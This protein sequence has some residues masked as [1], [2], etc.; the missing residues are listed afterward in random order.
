[1]AL[2]GAPGPLPMQVHHFLGAALECDCLVLLWSA[3]F[4]DLGCIST[5][6]VPQHSFNKLMAFAF[7]SPGYT[8][9]PWAWAPSSR[10]LWG[11]PPW[12]P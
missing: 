11:N 2:A 7:S 10:G 8:E 3:P 9:P 5:L 4:L 1:M 12:S 6:C